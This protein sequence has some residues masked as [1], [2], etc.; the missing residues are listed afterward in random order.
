MHVGFRQNWCEGL[1]C[2]CVFCIALH[3]KDSSLVY[4]IFSCP[5]DIS[6]AKLYI[7]FIFG[8]IYVYV[9]IIK[10]AK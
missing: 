10:M 9:L 5:N 2:S 8:Y 7:Q 3:T 1:R 4:F 6:S